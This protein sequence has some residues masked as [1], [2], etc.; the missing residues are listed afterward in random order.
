MDQITRQGFEN[1]PGYEII[2]RQ[3]STPV[4]FDLQLPEGGILRLPDYGTIAEA[5]AAAWHH[6]HEQQ[7]F[8]ER[9]R[10]AAPWINAMIQRGQRGGQRELN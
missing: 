4:R 5:R 3:D 6:F 7:Q 8:V 10:E 1:P 2:T 9:L